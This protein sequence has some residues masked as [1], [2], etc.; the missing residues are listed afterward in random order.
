M[1]RRT[2]SRHPGREQGGQLPPGARIRVTVVSGAGPALPVSALHGRGSGDLLDVVLASLPAPAPST[3]ARRADS[4]VALVVSPMWQVVVAERL[5][6]EERVVVDSVA[7]TTVD[8]VDSL[9]QIA[10]R[11]GCCGHRRP[12]PQGRHGSGTEYTRACAPLARSRRPRWP[13][14]SGRW[15]GDS[16]NRISGAHH[17]TEAGRALVIASTSGSGRRGPPIPAGQGDRPRA[18]ADSVGYPP[19]LSAKTVGPW[20]SSRQR[21]IGTGQLDQRVPTGS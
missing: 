8:P 5:A 6:N 4:P 20:T 11:P 7:G 14:C 18:A 1:L 13:W 9:V 2:A 10:D 15:R 17:G 3:E 19:Q 21:S 16:A 12:A